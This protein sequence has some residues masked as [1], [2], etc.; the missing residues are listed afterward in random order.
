MPHIHY[1]FC[2]VCGTGDLQFVFRVKD[3]TVSGREFDVV[4]C[5]NCTVRITQ[6][7]PDVDHIGAYY[8]SEDYISHSDSKKGLINKLYQKVRVR[9]MQQKAD[10]VKKY[11][12]L[13][14]GKLLD[15]GCGTGTFLQAMQQQG[16]EVTGLEPDAGAREKAR[17]FAIDVKPS[18]EIFNLEA[19]GFDAISLWHVLEHVHTLQE[20]VSQLKKL[21]KP[22]GRL[23]IAVPNY[24]SK[25]AGVYEQF[26]A[27]YDVPRHLYHFSP[28]AMGTL[29]KRHG[30]AI[31][32]M[33]P[34]WFDS[35]YVDMLSSKYKTGK[36]N[37]ISAG[38]HGLASNMNA[39]GKVEACCSVIYVVK[40]KDLLS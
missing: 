27:G 1:D 9:T 22:G 23:F 13:K 31:E 3:Y 39:L 37:Y 35:F 7:V 6:D 16:W 30:L 15:V 19:S 12:G 4:H 28:E 14:Q 38:L 5:E 11:T 29:L 32:K 34:M 2:P 25:D 10:T 17:Q 36:I 33:L 20:Y 8:Q 21:L 18:H 40:A 24:T 26:W